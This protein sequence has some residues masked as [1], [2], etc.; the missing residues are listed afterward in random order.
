M[1]FQCSF[2]AINRC[3]FNAACSNRLAFH[4]VMKKGAFEP[5]SISILFEFSFGLRIGPTLML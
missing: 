3:T 4:A 2:D 5:N 1:H